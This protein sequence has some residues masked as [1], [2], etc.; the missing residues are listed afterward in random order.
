MEAIIEFLKSLYSP[1]KLV[2]LVRAGGYTVLSIIVFSETGLFVGFFLPGDSLLFTA[3]LVAGSFPGV[4]N[5]YVM[6]ILLCV[7]AVTGDATGYYIGYKVGAPMYCWPDRWWFKRK[8]LL[9]AK[10]FYERHGGKA[11]FLARFVPFA[12]TFAPIVAGIAQMSYAKFASYN[13]VGGICWVTSMCV[14]GY[15]LGGVEWVRHNLEKVVLIIVFVS[16]LPI[17]YGYWKEKNRP[18]KAVKC[19][20]GKKKAKR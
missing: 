2:E 15:F 20:T 12:R 1:D 18:A 6:I 7:M 9:Y 3:G 14:A 16:I 11:I 17:I 10:D 4:L 19:P 13:V 8:H 5:I